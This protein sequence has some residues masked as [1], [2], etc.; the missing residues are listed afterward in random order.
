M[1]FV[2]AA[3]NDAFN[4][5]VT[6]TYPAT[7]SA[8][9]V[10]AVAAT[11]HN[12]GLAFFSS[13]GAKSVDLEPPGVGILSTT[14]GNTYGSFDGT[15]MATPHVA[16]AAALVEDRF[17]ERP[18]TDQGAAHELGRSSRLARGQD[19]DGGRLNIGNALACANEPLVLLARLP[20]GSSRVS[21]TYSDQGHRRE[22][23]VASRRRQRAATVNGTPVALSASTP[24]SGLYTGSY[25][26]TGPGALAVT[27][28]VS[29]GASN[30]TQT[31][32]GNAFPNYTCQD[33][34]F[35]W[36]EISSIPQLGSADGDDTFSTLNIVPVPF[37]G[38]T[39]TAYISSNGFRLSARAPVLRRTSTPRSRRPRRRTA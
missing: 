18:C 39:R 13:Y 9:A 22:L 38:Q 8:D 25:T 11:D 2:A 15:S 34:P 19:G 1:L 33:A 7:Y 16:G 3:G 4:N 10:L 32:N 30:A 12:D 5:D 37:F 24:D 28:T 6:P 23:R 35:S 29:V 26:V 21:A 17:P 20:P 36:V 14:P 27:A 31:A